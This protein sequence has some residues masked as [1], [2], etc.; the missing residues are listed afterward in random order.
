MQHGKGF[1]ER[2]VSSS[3]IIPHTTGLE[4]PEYNL[5]VELRG[6][7]S[8]FQTKTSPLGPG[9]LMRDLQMPR[10]TNGGV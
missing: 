2:A 8:P 4:R 9:D 3:I 10:Q 1:K 7:P 5:H 6:Q